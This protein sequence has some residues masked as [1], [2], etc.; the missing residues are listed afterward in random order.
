MKFPTHAD[1]RGD[2]PSKIDDAGGIAAVFPTSVAM[3]RSGIN[4][5]PMSFESNGAAQVHPLN[6]VYPRFNSVPV[7]C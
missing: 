3:N 7:F 4:F 2:E 1:V 6:F 5:D